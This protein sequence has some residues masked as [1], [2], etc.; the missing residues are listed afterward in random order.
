MNNQ[1]EDYIIRFIS[2]TETKED[3]H[4]LK[5]WLSVSPSR[6][7]ELKKWLVAWD[8]AGMIDALNIFSPDKAYQRFIFRMT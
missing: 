6:R 2:R 1:A 8:A 4:K 5:K 7:N 3:V